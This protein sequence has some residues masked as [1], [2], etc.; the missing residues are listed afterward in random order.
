MIRSFLP[1]QHSD[2]GAGGCGF[3]LRF[4]MQRMLVAMSAMLHHFDS[5]G[6]IFLVLL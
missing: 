4:L 2:C 5:V 3:L 1:A 6:V